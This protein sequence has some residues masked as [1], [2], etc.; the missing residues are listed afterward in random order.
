MHLYRNNNQY[1]LLDPQK[2][3][4]YKISDNV[5][6]MLESYN[7]EELDKIGEQFNLSVSD[8][9][10]TEIVEEN[11]EKCNRLILNLSD[12]C[13]LACKYCYANEG[14]Y[15]QET[16]IKNMKFD[17]LKKVYKRVSTLYPEG[18]GQIQFF[19]GE[20]LLNKEVLF[21][22]VKW[23]KEY[24]KALGQESPMF[25]M[26]TNGTLIDEECIDFFNEHFTSITL[27]LDGIKEINDEKRFYNNRNDSVYDNVLKVIELMN[28]NNRDF[29][30]CIEGTIHD[31]H[32]HKFEEQ[33]TIESY[34]TLTGL[35]VDL[36]HISPLID[37]KDQSPE[38]IKSYCNFFQKW[39]ENEFKSEIKNT[40]TK[41]VANLMYTSKQ[42]KTVGNGC[43]ATDTDIA[44]DTNGIMY[45]CFM[46]IGESK[47]SIGSPSE[48]LELQ[49]MKLSNIREELRKAN[50]NNE[51]NNCWS[52]PV[53]SKSYG[54]C[55]GARFLSHGDIAKPNKTACEIGK[56]V[57]ENVFAQTYEKYGMK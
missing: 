14:S 33:G 45:P 39:V 19:G 51:C 30:I 28:S 36:V 13:N 37:S 11:R 55:I 42:K 1:F 6:S 10:I 49:Q 7:S 57:I 26:V 53:C 43:G 16:Y 34:S 38:V 15:G 52:K 24:S 21:S 40:K 31:S 22:S 41:M 32:I 25:T 27:S 44:S 20:P 23:I 2:I 3:K 17:T 54:H 56:T 4:L 35:D 47:F 48:N 46:F 12:A 18:V 29:N 5:S 8:N 50:E 9:T